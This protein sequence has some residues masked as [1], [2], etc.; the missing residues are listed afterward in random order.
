MTP[1]G[2]DEKTLSLLLDQARA[3]TDVLAVVLFGSVARG[4]PGPSSDLDVCLVLRPN[5]Q[6]V[7]PSEKRVVYMGEVDADVQVYQQLPLYVRRRVLREGR[8]VLCKDEDALY[9]LAYRTVQAYEDFKYVYRTYQD[10]M[11]DA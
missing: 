7:A 4:D 2:R 1:R 10:A 11:L 3:D 8:V 9:D 6:G 5:V